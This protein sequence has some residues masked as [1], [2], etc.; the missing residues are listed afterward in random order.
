MTAFRVLF[1]DDEERVLSGL[2]RM[3]EPHRNEIICQFVTTGAEALET[4][5]RE[6][7][8]AIVSDMQMPGMDG[9]TLLKIA[10]ERHPR[11]VRLVLSAHTELEA[12]MRSVSVSHQFLTKPCPP[13][14]LLETIRRTC[15]L[16]TLME[17]EA[18]VATVGE[19]SSLPSM[20][21]V[22]NEL[23]KELA[24]PNY[25]VDSISGIV[26]QDIGMVAQILHMVNSAYFGMPRRIASVREAI[27]YIGVETINNLTLSIELFRSFKGAEESGY[28]IDREQAHNFIVAKLAKEIAP[29]SVSKDDA[30]LAGLLHDVGRL[31][32]ATKYPAKYGEV[33]AG[34]A[35][36]GTDR[37]EREQLLFGATHA[38][39][40]AYLLG[41]WNLPYVIVEAVAYHE[42]PS[43]GLATDF[44]LAHAVWIADALARGMPGDGMAEIALEKLEE[45]GVRDRLEGWMTI[46]DELMETSGQN[47]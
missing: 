24:R 42:D 43:Q 17:N 28:C 5:D 18:L 13:E 10:Q 4:L 2:R 15:A 45:L 12:T 36:N 47:V 9:A 37:G 1:V 25:S 41:L 44:G 27:G 16:Q 38:Q 46:R 39:V 40:G 21:R 33:S 19:I 6:C 29:D 23:T 3:L 34:L 11:V 31:I 30:Y 32:L 14:H 22:Y 35:A 20:P 26:E 7:F 8:D